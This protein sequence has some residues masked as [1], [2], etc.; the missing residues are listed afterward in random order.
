MSALVTALPWLGTLLAGFLGAAASLFSNFSL[1][2]NESRRRSVEKEIAATL[3]LPL[4][5]EPAE[6]SEGRDTAPG[7][8]DAPDTTGEAAESPDRDV[9]TGRGEIDVASSRATSEIADVVRQQSD[10][11][12]LLVV[13]YY[14]QGLTQASVSFALSMTFSVIGFGLIA[15]AVIQGIVHPDHAL[16]A[17]IT[18]VAG[19]VNQGVASLFFRR[20]DKGRELMM[21]LIDKLRK[22]RESEMRFVAGLTQIEQAQA[23]GLKDALRASAALAFTDS[24]MSLEHLAN[25]VNSGAL[26]RSSSNITQG[27]GGKVPHTGTQAVNGQQSSDDHLT[28]S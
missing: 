24:P 28:T 20:A 5:T 12:A 3:G 16:P 21:Q 10:G 18:A 2:K 27:A 22:D 15:I 19:I 14:A 26:T 6:K 11:H 8:V 25:L 13:K 7:S 9:R 4:N 1:R 17:G 23:E